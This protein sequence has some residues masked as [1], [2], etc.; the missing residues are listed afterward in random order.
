MD[1]SWPLS[2][3]KNKISIQRSQYDVL[4]WVLSEIQCNFNN[5]HVTLVLSFNPQV[6]SLL[7]H[8]SH[9]LHD[10]TKSLRKPQVVTIIIEWMIFCGIRFVN[11][12][13]FRWCQWLT[14]SIHV[15]RLVT[16]FNSKLC[17][18][19]L[20]MCLISTHCNRKLSGNNCL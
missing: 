7:I 18:D 15:I 11:C 16:I 6:E 10:T 9:E 5:V 20:I 3:F 14:L 17:C 8:L 13:I 12:F 4:K 1:T 19:E 2:F